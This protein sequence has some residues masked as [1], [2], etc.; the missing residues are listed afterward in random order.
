MQLHTLRCMA[1]LAEVSGGPC[2]VL[3]LHDFWRHSLQGADRPYGYCPA[4]STIRDHLQACERKGLA[5]GH[6]ASRRGFA[7]GPTTLWQA[8]PAGAAAIVDAHG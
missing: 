3:E 5:A 8:T 4:I 1:R 7:G 6:K 2:S